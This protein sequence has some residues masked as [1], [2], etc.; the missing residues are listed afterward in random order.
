MDD[1]SS[2]YGGHCH[3]FRHYSTLVA[4]TRA[5]TL[6]VLLLTIAYLGWGQ[7]PEETGQARVVPWADYSREAAI[8]YLAACLTPLLLWIESEYM[9]RMLQIVVAA[10]DLEK[11]TG[12][13]GFFSSYDSPHRWVS[14]LLCSIAVLLLDFIFLAD[15]LTPGTSLAN[16]G[17]D[18][19]AALLPIGLLVG[20]GFAY[21]RAPWSILSRRSPLTLARIEG[22]SQ[23]SRFQSRR[24]AND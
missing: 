1:R 15:V 20:F 7:G 11:S 9:K 22:S 18:L 10:G 14:P 5:V 13:P 23:V 2:I 16:W 19:L 4:V 6:T 8:L 12:E 17:A 3:L 24:S 21:W